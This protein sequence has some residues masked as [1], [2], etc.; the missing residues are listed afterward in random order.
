MK[1]HTDTFDIGYDRGSLVSASYTSPF[2]L[3]GEVESVRVHLK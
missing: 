2:A 1:R 3:T